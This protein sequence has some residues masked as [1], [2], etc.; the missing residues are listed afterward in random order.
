[1]IYREKLNISLLTLLPLIAK[2][3]EIWTKY[4]GEV[5]MSDIKGNFVN[6]YYADIN[7]PWLDNH[8]FLLFETSKNPTFDM[9]ELEE[10][11][12]FTT[13]YPLKIRDKF[14]MVYAFEIPFDNRFDYEEIMTGNYNRMHSDAKAQIIK[15]W[16]AS[17]D[18]QLF[19]NLYDTKS[20]YGKVTDEM[21]EEEDYFDPAEE[22]LQDIRNKETLVI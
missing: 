18:T 12:N 20:T 16:L 9:K 13:K 19:K 22:M 8:V 15:F 6:G 7:K 10:N 3:D 14:Y 11:E 1:M 2:Q 5:K 17:P 4:T 21:I